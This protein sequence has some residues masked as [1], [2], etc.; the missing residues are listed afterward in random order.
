MV[1]IVR[2]IIKNTSCFLLTDKY[3]LCERTKAEIPPNNQ[4]LSTLAIMTRTGTQIGTGLGI[5][6]YKVL[7]TASNYFQYFKFAEYDGITVYDVLYKIHHQILLIESQKDF[8]ISLAN[9][10]AVITVSHLTNFGACLRFN[11]INLFVHFYLEI[12]I[13][14]YQMIQFE[15]FTAL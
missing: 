9:N 13:L 8:T 2:I 6:P 11:I 7:S 4:V 1:L 12:F 15:F 14:C 5:S 3:L 10:V